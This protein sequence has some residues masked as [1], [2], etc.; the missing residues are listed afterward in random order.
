MELI[1]RFILIATGNEE[2]TIKMAKVLAKKLGVEKELRKKSLS[3]DEWIKMV[4]G[5]KGKSRKR[6]QKA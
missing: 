4:F 5:K 6:G 3:N 1:A 2:Y